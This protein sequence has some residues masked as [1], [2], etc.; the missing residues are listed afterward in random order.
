LWMVEPFDFDF[1]FVSDVFAFFTSSRITNGSDHL[2]SLSYLL[3]HV[4]D[5]LVLRLESYREV[6]KNEAYSILGA[7][8]SPPNFDWSPNTVY[9]HQHKS[10]EAKRSK[11]T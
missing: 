3:S 9:T 10:G 8:Y 2:T 4:S 6:A 1:D 5:I 7:S 11:L